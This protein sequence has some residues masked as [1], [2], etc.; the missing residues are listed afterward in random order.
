MGTPLDVSIEEVDSVADL[1]HRITELFTGH[2]SVLFR[3]HRCEHWELVPRIARTEFRIRYATDIPK[4]EQR[5]LDEFE[6]LSVPH[7]GGRSI[8]STWDV[9]ALAQHH[10]LPTRLLDWTSNPLVALWFA[11]EQPTADG[12]DGAL[13]AYET[14]EGDIVDQKKSPFGLSKTQIFRPRHHDSRIVAQ[15]GWFTVHKYM[16]R[17]QR[18]SSLERIKAHRSELRKFVVP[19]KYFPSL[20]D[21]L[22]RCGIQHAALFPDLSGLCN[23]LRWHFSPLSDEGDYDVASSL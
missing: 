13:W 12:K 14:D 5:M 9:L 6:R 8:A 11:V 21:D 23:Q 10:G 20:R 4:T 18:F 19:C 15:A 22:A 3:G 17:D 1:L 16:E 2:G 7:L